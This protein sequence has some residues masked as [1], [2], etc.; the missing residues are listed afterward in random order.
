MTPTAPVAGVTASNMDALNGNSGSTPSAGVTNELMDIAA[1]ESGK[2]DNSSED[3]Q[4]DINWPSYGADSALVS[5]VFSGMEI[6]FNTLYD[7]VNSP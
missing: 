7:I 4:V 1:G 6:S 5:D 3:I 2:N